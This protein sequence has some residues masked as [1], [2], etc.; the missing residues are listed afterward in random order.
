MVS[1]DLSFWMVAG[2]AMC[3]G[4]RGRAIQLA[5]ELEHGRV[6]MSRVTSGRERHVL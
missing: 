5:L 6:K 1:L 3:S 4:Q 2:C